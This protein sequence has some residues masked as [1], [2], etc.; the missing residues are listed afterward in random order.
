MLDQVL[1]KHNAL[2]GQERSGRKPW[3]R[4]R[5]GNGKLAD[6]SEWRAKL[7]Y[8]ASVMSLYL[9][10]VSLGTMGRVERRMDDAGGG[11]KE[12]KVAV[13]ERGGRSGGGATRRWR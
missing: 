9:N 8:H 5:F 3:Q 1:R 13:N 7:T 12:I 6:L 2:R 10:M 11:P 4:I